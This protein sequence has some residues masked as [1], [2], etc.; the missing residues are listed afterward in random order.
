MCEFLARRK[1]ILCIIGSGLLL[2][3]WGKLVSCLSSSIIPFIIPSSGLY[4]DVSENRVA[5]IVKLFL[6]FPRCGFACSVQHFQGRAQL[7]PPLCRHRSKF[8]ICHNVAQLAQ[9]KRFFLKS[10]KSLQQLSQK[11]SESQRY[12]TRGIGN[13]GQGMKAFLYYNS[14]CA[15]NLSMN[16]QLK[17]NYSETNQYRGRAMIDLLT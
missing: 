15:G 8:Q 9:A 14:A 5:H 13:W 3:F 16:H 11:G 7:Y 4:K 17:K 12:D 1:L 2:F 6:F 10:S